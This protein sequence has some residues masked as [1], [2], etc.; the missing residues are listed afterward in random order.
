MISSELF[1]EKIL[2]YQPV[3]E[4]QTTSG[5]FQCSQ[6]YGVPEQSDYSLDSRYIL[7]KDRTFSHFS[8]LF[9]NT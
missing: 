4:V 5:Y 2:T 9:Q 8:K 1:V 3:W 6:D 7:G